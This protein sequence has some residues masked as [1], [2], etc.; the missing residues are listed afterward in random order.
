MFRSTPAIEGHG[1]PEKPD[2]SPDGE[3]RAVA[4]RPIV[5]PEYLENPYDGARQF[6]EH[7]VQSAIS[8]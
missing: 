3:Y 8:V 6:Q 5:S 4:S 7:F 2:L 1:C